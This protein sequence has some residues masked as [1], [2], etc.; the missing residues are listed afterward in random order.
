M[1]FASRTQA[2]QKLAKELTKYRFEDSAVL[3]LSDGGVVIGA[4]IAAELHCPLMFLL[5]QDI[6]LPGEKTAVGVI[7][8]NGGFVY[9]DLFS[10]GELEELVG[11]YHGVIDQM[12]EQKWHEINR[13][14]SDGGLVDP[15][16]LEN[17]NI[18][19]VSDGFLN[20]TS[21]LATMNFLKPIKA[22]KLII[23]TPFASVPAVD[24]M[25]VLGD[26]LYALEVIDGTFEL[27]HYYE[28][29]D[30]PNREDIIRIL[31]EAILKWK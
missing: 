12:K 31:N 16:I 24:K 7:D 4:Q 8:Q 3:A 15:S 11:E 2:G 6:V 25:H 5:T 1:Y 10:T 21:L 22:S 30:I 9:N 19:I 14:L 28:T 26:E 18:I 13:L 29:D 23:A 27:D 17:R 20:G